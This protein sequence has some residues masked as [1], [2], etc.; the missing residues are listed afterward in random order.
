MDRFKVSFPVSVPGIWQ[1]DPIGDVQD[2]VPHLRAH[3]KKRQIPNDTVGRPEFI[4]VSDPWHA[5]PLIDACPSYHIVAGVRLA[6][7]PII[8]QPGQSKCRF[9]WWY[10]DQK[11]ACPC[12]RQ[13]E[14]L[15][16][17]EHDE[18]EGERE[19]S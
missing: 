10:G 9:C 12:R 16:Q 18:A 3:P 19:F 6:K 1:E 17:T 5:S 11:R 14:A 13:L 7:R 15:I 2:A 8:P 4:F